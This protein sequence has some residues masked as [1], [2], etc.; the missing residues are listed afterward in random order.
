VGKRKKKL[1]NWLSEKMRKKDDARKETVEYYL[2]D[3]KEKVEKEE[4]SK[5]RQD[6]PKI[7]KRLYQEM[8]EAVDKIT[9]EAEQTQMKKRDVLE[10]IE[11][12]LEITIT[13]REDEDEEQ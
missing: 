3:I 9:L 13:H 7:H 12:E 2:G 11:S 4:L 8:S 5:I 1:I 10:K 6:L